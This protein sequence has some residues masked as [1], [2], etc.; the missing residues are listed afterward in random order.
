MNQRPP[1]RHSAV[2]LDLEDLTEVDHLAA[3]ETEGNASQMIRKLIRE[4]LAARKQKP[5]NA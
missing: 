5:T 2:R 1:R 4:A 3:L